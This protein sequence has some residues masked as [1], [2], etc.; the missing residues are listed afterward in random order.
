MRVLGIDAGIATIGWAVLDLGPDTGQIISCGTRTFDAPETDKDRRPTNTI[1]REKRGMRRVI[2]RRSQRMNAVRRLLFNHR[3]LDDHSPNA[4]AL[5]LDPWTLRADA[6]D[7][8]LQDTEIAA[9]F[10][11][12]ARHRGFRSNSKNDRGNDAGSE[13]SQML[14][15]I[16]ATR[17]RLAQWR[18]VGELFARDAQFAKRKRNRGGGF[19]RSVLRDDLRSEVLS[20]CRAQRKFGNEKLSKDFEEAFLEA[21]FSQR[22]LRDSDDL[23][24][25]CPFVPGARR[26]ARRSYSFE[27]F[28]LSSRL[29]TVRI[30]APGVREPTRLD[31]TQITRVIADFGSQKKLTWKWL[32]TRLRL[33]PQVRFA[34]VSF[35]DEKNDFVARAGEAAAGSYAIREIVGEAGWKALLAQPAVLDDLAAILS[36][37]SDLTSICRAVR[38]LPIE[39]AITEALIEAAER[40]KFKAFSGAGHISATAA[41][42]LLPHLGRGLTYSEA[43]SAVGFNHAERAELHIDDIRN[44]IARKAVSEVMKQVKAVVNEF[45]LPDVVNVELARDVGKGADERDEIRRGIDK[46]NR[47][48]DRFRENFE[49]LLGRQPYNE[50]EILRFE[51]WKEQNGRCLYTDAEIPV[52]SLSINDNSVQID[53][54][55]PWSRFGDDSFVNK[56]LCFASA[57]AQKKGRTPYEWFLSERSP[58]DWRLFEARVESCKAIKGRKKRGFYL[59]R[60]AAEV[61]ENFRSRN[62]GDTRYATRLTLDLIRREYYSDRSTVHVLAR[63]GALTSKLRRGWG[64]EFLKKDN[65]GNRLPDDRHHALDAIVVAACNQSMLQRL[66]KAFQDAERRGLPRDFGQLDQPWPGF[67]EAA[68]AAVEQVFVSRAE[69]R[70][71]RGEI[72]GATIRQIR[73]RDGRT[74]VFERRSIDDLKIADLDRVKDAERNKAVIASLHSWIEAGRPKDDPPLSPKGDVIR[75]VRLATTGKL[76]VLIRGGTADRGNI[77]RVDVYENT[78]GNARSKFAFVPVYAHQIFA[79]SPPYRYF[80]LRKDYENWPSISSEQQ[81]L[82][83]IHPMTLLRIS[84]KERGASENTTAVGYFRG[85]D[86]NDGRLNIS[87]HKSNDT[88]AKALRS[89]VSPTT[90]VSMEKIYVDRLGRCFDVKNER[91]TWRGAACT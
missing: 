61:E 91:R 85:F 46:R 62:L 45:G 51:L 71:A 26:A 27:M 65:D 30:V 81:F 24:G 69:R 88:R 49:E 68:I 37:R 6:L 79:D 5:G 22:P 12:I 67:R 72:H 36:F 47:E 2:R 3:L 73:E 66:T 50:T 11:H 53:H 39:P 9:V 84:H 52:L 41:R 55:L 10:G 78:V 89:R 80:V 77:V 58:D 29:N 13:T 76:G 18:T 16:A 20:I 70:R 90:V 1:R 23:V 83:S 48:R 64:L 33:D 42:M 40:G 35:E 8:P 31:A 87:D 57:N 28:R 74:I 60:N 54:I 14:S 15:A 25:M 59:R 7:R 82:F 4:L 43:C 32:R 86:V 56:T 34:D 21:A 17:E 63:P 38:A 44:P 19:S 75:K